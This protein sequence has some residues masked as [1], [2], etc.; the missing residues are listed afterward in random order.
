MSHSQQSIPDTSASP[1]ETE[2]EREIRLTEE[3]DAAADARRGQVLEEFVAEQDQAREEAIAASK[4]RGKG[5]SREGEA[6]ELTPERF[7]KEMRSM[8]TVGQKEQWRGEAHEV[9]S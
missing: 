1:I 4:R 5:P 3:F 8:G 2:L 7:T 6:L 9:R